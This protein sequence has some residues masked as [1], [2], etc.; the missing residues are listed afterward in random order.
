MRLLVGLLVLAAMGW[1]MTLSVAADDKK[2]SKDSKDE[3]ASAKTFVKKASAA[4]L[5]E[6]NLGNLGARLARNP[7]VQRFAQQ[8]VF[9]HQRAN[10]QL[11]ILANRKALAMAKGMNDKHAKKWKELSKMSG[12]DFDSAFMQCMVADHEEAVKL[13]ESASKNC[14]DAGLKT[15]AERTLPVLRKHLEVAREVDKTVNKDGKKEKGKDR[16]DK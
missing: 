1:M 14:D 10:E 4:G 16:S 12:A 7:N 8:M 2:D 13:F 9:D 3:G 6:V 15:W 5:A 11:T